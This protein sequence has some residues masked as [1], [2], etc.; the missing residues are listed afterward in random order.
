MALANKTMAYLAGDAEEANFQYLSGQQVVVP[1]PATA[2]FSTYTLK[3]PG[4]SAAEAIVPRTEKQVDLTLPQAV[5]PGNYTLVGD[6]GRW[7]S[8]FSVNVSPEES[9][10]GRI[11]PERIEELFDA[12]AVLSVGHGISLREALQ[13]RWKQPLELFGWLMILVLLA[14]AIENLLANRFYRREPDQEERT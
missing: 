12:G 14:L 5:T 2:H 4:V 10:L 6:D 13:G 1:L 3:G 7:I 9:Q 11:P 8:S